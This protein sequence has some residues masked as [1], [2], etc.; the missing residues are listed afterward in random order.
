MIRLTSIRAKLTGLIVAL[1]VLLWAIGTNYWDSRTIYDLDQFVH[2]LGDLNA[3]LVALPEAAGRPLA[4]SSLPAATT[5][6]EWNLD[7]RLD[8]LDRRLGELAASTGATALEGSEKGIAQTRTAIDDYRNYLATQR[9]VAD[10]IRSLEIRIAQEL[11]VVLENITYIHGYHLTLLE[12]FIAYGD[13]AFADGGTED[14]DDVQTEVRLVGLSVEIYDLVN[15]LDAELHRF[16]HGEVFADTMVAI[17]AELTET[18]AAFE[19]LSLDPQDGIMVEEVMLSASAIP[20]HLIKH[21]VLQAES[22]RILAALQAQNRSIV[23]TLTGLRTH[24]E[25]VHH[26]FLRTTRIKA[27]FITLIMLVI[28]VVA[29]WAGI[30]DASRIQRL[31]EGADQFRRKNFRHRIGISGRDEFSDLAS[32]FNVMAEEIEVVFEDLSRSREE[33]AATAREAEAANQAKSDFLANMSHEIRTPMNGILGMAE[34][35]LDT[36]LTAEQRDNLTILECS[37]RVLLEIINDV[38]D[39]SKLEAQRL[40]MESREF[41]LQQAVAC[42]TKP[43]EARANEKGLSL[44]VIVEPDIPDDLVGDSTRLIQVLTNLLGNAVKFTDVGQVTLHIARDGREEDADGGATTT[45]LRFTVA[46]TGIGVSREQQETIFAR[47]TQA[48]SSIT[49]KYGGTGL[50][51]TISQQLIILMGGDIHLTSELGQGTTVAFVLPF[52]EPV[53]AASVRGGREEPVAAGKIAGTGMRVLVVEDNLVNQ[54]VVAKMLIKLGCAVDIVGN[55]LEGVRSVATGSYDLILMDQQMPVMDGLEATRAIRCEE[56]HRH[57]IVALTANVQ[58]QNREACLAAGM[59]D[60]LT[61]PVSL[62]NL[63]GMLQRWAKRSSD[64]VVS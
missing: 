46:D 50:G 31:A 61:K 64:L 42:V 35:T 5:D 60:H 41:Q 12:N 27:T 56:S 14:R 48:D 53:A 19:D 37:A 13:L 38:L 63:R 2:S 17:L 22:T 11:G 15:R 28:L 21:N 49:R 43:L 40:V 36:N 59:D 51:M 18:L 62:E 32:G 57:P 4:S 1:L 23:A 52:G 9:E 54:K 3:D 26:S 24:A 16:M 45:R 30:H 44:Q 8:D 7:D 20:P 55:G 58:P 6:G 47:F 10:N 25:D 29:L 34:L 33:L 39:F